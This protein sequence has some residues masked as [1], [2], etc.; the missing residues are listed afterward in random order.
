VRI[1]NFSNSLLCRNIFDLGVVLHRQAHCKFMHKPT[2]LLLPFASLFFASC[3]GKS[4]DNYDTAATPAYDE[5]STAVP[6]TAAP[7]YGAAAYEDTAAVP[8]TVVETPVAPVAPATAK[9]HYV[10]PGDSLWKISKQ[11]GV[12]ID[13]IKVANNMTTDTVVLGKKM[14][15]PAP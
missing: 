7:T 2:F 11:Y 5:A 15:I 14:I 12:T 3:G 10:A 9:E 4:G 8:T 6:A 13:A 1:K